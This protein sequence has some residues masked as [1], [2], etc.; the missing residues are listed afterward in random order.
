[1]NTIDMYMYIK[2]I[3]VNYMIGAKI[4]YL[5]L[6]LYSRAAAAWPGRSSF[7]SGEMNTRGGGGG[8]HMFMSDWSALMTPQKAAP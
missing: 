2:Y 5:Y 1:M 6:Y 4:N 8:W 3:T 7:I